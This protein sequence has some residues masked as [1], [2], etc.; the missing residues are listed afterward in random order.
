[1]LMR[2]SLLDK[3]V[4]RSSETPVFRMLPEAHVIK[5]GGRSVMDAGRAVVYPVVD[6][7]IGCLETKKLIIGTGGGV[8]AR[9]VLSIGID[10]GLP[11]GVLAQLALADSLGNAHILGTL[12]SPHGVVAIPPEM[13]GHLL[14]LL[15][16]SVPGVIFNGDPPY[17][18]WEHPPQTGRIPPHR[19]DAGSFLLAEC[20]GCKSLT[21]VKDVDGLYDRDPHTKPDA[22]LIREIDTDE[23]KRRNLESLPFE[24]VLLDLL[25]NARQLKSF[26]VVNGRHPDRIA[27]A[28]N[29]EHVGTIVHAGAKHSG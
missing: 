29:G 3:D 26:Q 20:F 18:L 10:L 23:L 6:A 11:T 28:L 27:A 14:P 9:H 16:A 7:L 24:R 5:I 22:D 15:I 8:R 1:M 12:L 4:Q 21:L 19:S 2:E 13:F 17:S 25:E